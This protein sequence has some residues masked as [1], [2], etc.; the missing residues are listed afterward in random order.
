MCILKTKLVDPA[1]F[2]N[3]AMFFSHKSKGV[4]VTIKWLFRKARVF[5]EVE[6]EELGHLMYR[7]RVIFSVILSWYHK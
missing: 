3:S 5:L 6:G 7:E 2:Q 4:T 1:L